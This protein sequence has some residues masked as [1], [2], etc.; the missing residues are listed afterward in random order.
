MAV[1]A[2]LHDKHKFLERIGGALLVP[3]QA[4][5]EARIVLGALVRAA[6]DGVP[7]CR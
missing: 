1:I 5:V 7:A 4:A 3:E 2:K 6:Q